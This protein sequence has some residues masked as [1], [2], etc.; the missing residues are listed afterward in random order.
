MLPKFCSGFALGIFALVGV[1]MLVLASAS[2][3]YLLQVKNK[4][5][6]SW[7]M[8][9]FFLCI[10]LSSIA[11]ILT[12][13]GTSW[14]W[15]FAPAQDAFII[16]GG[17]FMVK[18]AYLYPS[19]DQPGEARIIVSVFMTLALVT[20][21]YSLFFALQFLEN[22]LTQI[23]EVRAY[24]LITPLAIAVAVLIFFR[25][26]QHWSA[27]QIN[28]PE[29][30]SRLEKAA[31]KTFIKP[32]NL[33]AHALRNFGLALSIGLIPAVVTVFKDALP[34]LVASFLFNFGVVLA[35]AVIM[36]VYLNY[37]PEPTTLSA[38]L[39]G[40]SLATM[41]LILG[42]AGVLFV[43]NTPEIQV[44]DTVVNF[45]YLVLLSSILIIVL[46]PLFFRS[47]LLGPLGR[48]LNG[49]REAEGGN[50]NIQVDA[51]YGD[52]IGF[53]TRSF[54]HMIHSLNDATQT[55]KN[56]SIS[57]ERE[58]TERT[59]E[60]RNINQQLIGEN[61]VRKST[62][63]KLD[64]QLRYEQAL[65][66]CSRSLL[67]AAEDEAAQKLVLVQSLDYL[68]IGAMAS[69]AYIYR[70]HQDPDFGFCMG[71]WQNPAPLTLL[72]HCMFQATKKSPG[73]GCLKR[74]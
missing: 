70:N 48:L 45:I 17:V 32:A 73:H 29:T 20:L 37:A 60:L 7:M 39:V 10:I 49:V 31:F 25:R 21:A 33:P 14:D 13:T 41:L 35:I 71:S 12:N 36:L 5:R 46:F 62:E 47:T 15:A 61:L 26:S 34:A 52:E 51:E 2:F 72:L 55:L 1:I 50:L 59:A 8:L 67:S 9:L 28:S 6:S 4:S 56:E 74:C 18:F 44:H 11:T 64:R 69:R 42:L 43:M 30:G 53:L 66:G 68:R 23:K 54:N 65:A 24:Y 38:K 16:L 27:I 3:G 57:L 19:D 40:I 22:L 63:E 58:V